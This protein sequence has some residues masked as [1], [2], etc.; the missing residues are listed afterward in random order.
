MPPRGRQEVGCVVGKH[1]PRRI[2]DHAPASKAAKAKVYELRRQPKT[3]AEAEHVMA[4]HGSRRRPRRRKTAHIP[5]GQQ[6][7]KLFD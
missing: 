2:V 6:Q 7:R 5:G 3:R 4:R 1:D